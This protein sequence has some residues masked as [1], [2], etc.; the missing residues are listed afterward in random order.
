MVANNVSNIKKD[1]NVATKNIAPH[2]LSCA[3]HGSQA[4][5]KPDQCDGKTR[6]CTA[7]LHHSGR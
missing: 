7:W 5:P 2:E 4:C 6:L 1:K 3:L